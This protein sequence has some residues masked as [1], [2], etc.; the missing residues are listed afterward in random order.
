ME[1][2][3][4]EKEKGKEKERRRVRRNWRRR[5]WTGGSRRGI[6]MV[7]EKQNPD[8]NLKFFFL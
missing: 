4:E 6:I 5:T 7:V 2:E 8:E 1:K 3:K